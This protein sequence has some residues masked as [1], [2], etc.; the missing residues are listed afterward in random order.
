M[1]TPHLHDFWK[2]TEK[3][4]KDFDSK[5][6]S[7]E[8]ILEKD[9]HRSKI[10]VNTC[11][12]TTLYQTMKTGIPMITLFNRKT[13]NIHPKILRLKESMISNKIIFEDPLKAS[14]HIK[15]IWD[16]PL[17][18]WNSDKILQ[19]RELFTE[20]CSMETKNNLKFLFHHFRAAGL[21]SASVL[22]LA[23]ET[24]IF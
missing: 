8:K 15:K 4:E 1:L 9:L 7:N 16:N 23:A 11:F 10:I 2:L 18:W 14:E 13:L 24:D 21:P 12:Q 20:Y 22:F 6:I 19:V 5:Y 3:F 17:D